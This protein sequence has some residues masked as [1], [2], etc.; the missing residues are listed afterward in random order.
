MSRLLSSQP[1]SERLNKEPPQIPE[2]ETDEKHRCRDL[3]C[4]RPM[5][6]RVA[7]DGETSDHPDQSVGK[8]GEC[9]HCFHGV[10]SG[11]TTQAQRPGP[12]DVSIATVARWPGS[13]QRM[14]RRLR[15]HLQMVSMNLDWVKSWERR[16]PYHKPPNQRELLTARKQR[17]RSTRRRCRKRSRKSGE[18][19]R[20]A[21]AVR[22][23]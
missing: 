2:S 23:C 18:A 3:R 5:L 16:K 10:C 19:H 4:K 21:S 17:C 15:S 11:L 13:L 14:V 7:D 22:R 12:R 1:G 9:V 6:S 8:L 20:P